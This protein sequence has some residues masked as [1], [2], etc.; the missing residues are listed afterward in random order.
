[1]TQPTTARL[2][3]F[4]AGCLVT[5]RSVSILGSMASVLA[6]LV[7]VRELTG[8]NSAAALSLLIYALP[9]L[10]YPLIGRLAD[11]VNRLV[12]LIAS[13]AIGALLISGVL[14]VHDASGIWLVYL[15]QLLQG[16]N[17]GLVSI[18]NDS[19]L[20]QVADRS[21]FSSLNGLLEAS[22][23]LARVIAPV[24]GVLIFT[25]FGGI[26][27][28]VAFDVATFACG[29]LLLAPLGQYGLGRS[30]VRPEGGGYLAAVRQGAAAIA[31]EPLLRDLV[32]AVSCC[33]LSIGLLS[34]VIYAVITDGLGQSASFAGTLATA[35]GAGGVLGGLVGTWFAR[36]PSRTR[37]G[38]ILAAGLMF[39]GVC[40]LLSGSVP[41]TVV[42]M[43]AL[44]VGGSLLLV[45]Y[46][47]GLQLQVD[48]RA[49]GRVFAVIDGAVNA[50]QVGGTAIGAVFLAA[51]PAQFRPPVTVSAAV[52]LGVLIIVLR[53]APG[54]AAVGELTAVEAHSVEE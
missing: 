24:V 54:P 27:W 11:S 13:Q 40:G 36:L 45:A 5:A 9:T 25:Q 2:P 28:V 23:Q 37:G 35:Q 26:K 47:T 43:A 33:M 17:S 20:P 39:T 18:A 14:L 53:S 22:G 44:G 15:M 10:A 51:F 52:L 42:G 16:V 8:S 21:Q 19:L 30:A 6:V 48:E 41:V 4:L 50:A 38:A 3:G 34:S 29:I 7:W 32:I 12:L 46:T 1:M 49:L 31:A